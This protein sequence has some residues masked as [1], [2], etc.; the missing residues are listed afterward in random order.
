LALVRTLRELGVD[1]ATVQRVLAREV[2]VTEVA[3]AHADALDVHIA[4]LRLH[5]AVLRTVARRG[6]TPKEL[7]LMN[8]VAQMTAEERRRLVHDFLDETFGTVDDPSGVE[9]RMRQAMPDLPDEPGTEQVEAW[10]ELAELVQDPGFRAR[11]RE[12]A[13]KGAEMHARGDAPSEEESWQASRT[14]MDK[15]G[16]A[17]ADG[18]EPA[19]EGA[20]P[21]IDELTAGMAGARD[22]PSSPA[23][24]RELADRLETFSDRRV[25]R[26]WQLI[27]TIN[28]WGC[29]IPSAAAEYEWFV[30]G[31]RASA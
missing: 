17:L 12:M 1:L 29:T 14:V 9:Q 19:S 13:E 7:E 23:F 24:R 16:A 27:G 26:Y 4:T 5:R 30:A 21:V 28:G 2:S 8:K 3:E 20:R 22:D 10:V 6:A 25:E 31:L 15:A 18:V 11:T